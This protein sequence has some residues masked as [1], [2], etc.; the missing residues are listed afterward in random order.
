MVKSIG[1]LLSSVA[2][3]IGRF[4]PVGQSEED[5]LDEQRRRYGTGE[6]DDSAEG[7]R[8]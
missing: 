3:F 1:K 2:E 5:I 7:D 6:P 8:R 4:W